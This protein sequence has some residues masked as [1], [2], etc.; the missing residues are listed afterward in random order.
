VQEILFVSSLV[1]SE[2]VSAQKCYIGL[3]GLWCTT[4]KT[5]RDR[6]RNH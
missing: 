1:E 4:D 5:C 3:V 2:N 6:Q